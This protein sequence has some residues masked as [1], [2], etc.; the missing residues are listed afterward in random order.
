MLLQ[1][2]KLKNDESATYVAANKIGT[3]LRYGLTGTVMQVS[4]PP[5]QALL[6]M[7]H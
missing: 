2:H 1:V 3:H 6:I 7:T 5:G 4:T